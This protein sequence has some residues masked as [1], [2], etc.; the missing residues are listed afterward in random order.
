MTRSTCRRL[1]LRARWLGP[2]AAVF[3]AF[4]CTD[5]LIQSA[6]CEQAQ[7]LR[8]GVPGRGEPASRAE[9]GGCGS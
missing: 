4:G 1:G 5:E 8:P 2:P 6:T 9:S 3:A 7:E